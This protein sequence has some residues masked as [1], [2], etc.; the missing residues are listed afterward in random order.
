LGQQSSVK[1]YV[2]SATLCVIIAWNYWIPTLLYSTTASLYGSGFPDFSKFYLAGHAWLSHTTPDHFIYPPTSLPFYGFFA[3]FNIDLAGRLWMIVYLITFLVALICLALTFSGV[4]RSYF[5]SLTGL[6]F[7]TSYPLLIMMNLGEG[8]LLVASLSVLSLALQRLKRENESAII[9][10]CAMLLKGPPVLLLVYFVLYRRNLRYLGRFL[11][12]TLVMVSTSLLVVPVQLYEFYFGTV[13]PKVS[14]VSSAGDLNQSLLWYTSS[15]GLNSALVAVA[16]VLIF[17]IFTVIIAR[18]NKISNP[19]RDDGMFL[20]NVLVILLLS[21]R[22]W[23]G[24]YVWVILPTALFLSNLLIRNV[25][26]LY[27]ATVF[28]DAFLLNSNLTQIFLRFSEAY[29]ILP[30]AIFGNIM[31]TVVLL[32]TIVRPSVTRAAR[33]RID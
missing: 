8:D 23:P 13:A 27:L 28:F 30:L 26:I 9:L 22:V 2:V 7:F 5:V 31:L 11:V 10:S 17:S 12:A 19:L 32:L 25:N 14:V 20:L 3:L 15:A 18:L 6:L 29:D 16:G 24:T 33:T 4:R 1:V 21:P